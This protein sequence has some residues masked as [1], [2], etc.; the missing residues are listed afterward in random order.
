MNL[1]HVKLV[2]TVLTFLPLVCLIMYSSTQS[3]SFVSMA[4]VSVGAQFL[5][6]RKFWVCPHCKNN[7]GRT[8]GRVCPY[9]GRELNV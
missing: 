4:L 9:C 1:K 6:R 8:D 2:S 3:Y 5:V 7:L